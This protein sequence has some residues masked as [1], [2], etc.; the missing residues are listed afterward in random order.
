MQKSVKINEITHEELQSFSQLCKV[1]ICNLID[2]EWKEFKNS[3][4]YE[5]LVLFADKNN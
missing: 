3:K 5:S 4:N 1:P 2:F